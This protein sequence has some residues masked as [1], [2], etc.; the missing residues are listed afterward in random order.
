MARQPALGFLTAG[1]AP[2]IPMGGSISRSIEFL[3]MIET[4]NLFRSV[5]ILTTA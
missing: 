1:V 3:R 5:V 4:M 2:G